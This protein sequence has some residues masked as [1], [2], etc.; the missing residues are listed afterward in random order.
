MSARYSK[1][2]KKQLSDSTVP[3]NFGAEFW[4]LIGILSGFAVMFGDLGGETV[5]VGVMVPSGVSK[6]SNVEW[7]GDGKPGLVFDSLSEKSDVTVGSGVVWVW[8]EGEG[9]VNSISDQSDNVRER[10]T[11]FGGLDEVWASV[12]MQVICGSVGL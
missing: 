4:P 9:V 2:E 3:L 12:W 11:A 10:T 7:S 6:D 5:W 1:S 8:K